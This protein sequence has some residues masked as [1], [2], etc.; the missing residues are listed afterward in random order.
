MKQFW[1]N[2]IRWVMPGVIAFIFLI[3]PDLAP[4]NIAHSTWFVRLFY[5]FY[6]S[7]S[8]FGVAKIIDNPSKIEEEV[9]KYRT[10]DKDTLIFMYILGH[11]FFITSATCLFFYGLATS[12][13]SVGWW[14]YSCAVLY[15]LLI[16]IMHYIICKMQIHYVKERV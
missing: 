11:L 3:L 1:V 2:T 8:F 7:N 14:K 12:Y 4:N 10:I 16:I 6:L 5:V 13:P 9:G 15:G